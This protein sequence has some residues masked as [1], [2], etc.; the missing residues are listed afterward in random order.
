MSEIIIHTVKSKSDLNKFVKFPWKIY[1]DDPNWVPPLLYD[2]K[3]V[4]NKEKNPFYKHAEM[5]MFLAERNGELVGRIAA[6]KND[7]HNKEHNDKVGFFGFFECINDQDVA[8]KLFEV[9]AEWLKAKGMEHMRGPASPSV[10]DIYAL[11]IDGFD[12]PP[13]ILMPYNP[14][15]YMDLIDNAGFEKAKDL[16]AWKISKEKME[17]NDKIKRVADIALQRSKASIRILNLK[18]FDNEL[19]KVKYVYNKAWQPNWGF[20]PLTDEEIDAL[21]ADLKPL[22]DPNLVLFLEIENKTVGFALV[23]PDYNFI[24]K[25]MNGRLLPFNFIKLFTKRKSIPWARIIIL[26]IIPE[27]QKR[28]L[29]AALYYDVMVRAAK[30]NIF[31]GEASW[32]LEDNEMMNRGAETMRGERYKQYRVYQKEI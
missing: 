23:M 28:G 12:D 21:A 7:L 11:L 18:D 27:F 24:F 14:K 8:N 15:Y 20:V 9:S 22:V 30:R 16:Y 19:E 6:V 13:R 17:T 26:G 29:D 4:L 1:K 2:I 5:E 10:N 3:K 31:R 25:E 32:I